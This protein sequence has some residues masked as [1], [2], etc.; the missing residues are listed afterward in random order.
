M[1]YEVTCK[2]KL[3]TLYIATS[4]KIC[5]S[6]PLIPVVTVALVFSEANVNLLS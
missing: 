4:A 5:R 2:N 3:H 6:P 1:N